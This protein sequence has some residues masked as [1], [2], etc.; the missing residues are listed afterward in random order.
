[1]IVAMVAMTA[2]RLMTAP[3]LITP[4]D[5]DDDVL[6]SAMK[7]FEAR[8]RR[9]RVAR[10]VLFGTGRAPPQHARKGARMSSTCG[11]RGT[12]GNM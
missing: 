4:A 3:M 9:V 7:V 10:V 2:A 11:A 12:F 8:G 1:M 5:N 6:A